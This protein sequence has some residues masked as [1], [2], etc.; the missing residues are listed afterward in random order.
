MRVVASVFLKMKAGYQNTM[1]VQATFCLVF[2]AEFT[3]VNSKFVLK[4]FKTSLGSYHL[5]LNLAPF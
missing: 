4:D 2:W 1:F 5:V 3:T